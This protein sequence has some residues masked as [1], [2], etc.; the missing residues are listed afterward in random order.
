MRN[1]CDLLVV[2][3]SNCITAGF[4]SSCMTRRQDTLS[5]LCEKPV[6]KKIN[7]LIRNLSGEDFRLGAI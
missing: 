1:G 4:V 7:G 5:H 6:N 3:P 2:K